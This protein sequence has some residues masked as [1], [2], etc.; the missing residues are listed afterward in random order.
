MPR[1]I[2][3]PCLVALA[4][5]VPGCDAASAPGGGGAVGD[6]L[7]S[8]TAPGQDTPPAADAGAAASVTGPRVVFLGTSLTAGLGLRRP[9]E[10]WPEQL[11]LRAEAAGIPFRVVNAGRSGDTSAGGV[12]RLDWILGDTVDV[13]V[14]ELG[15]NDGLR[16]LP[17][18]EVAANLG[19]VIDRTRAA[20][21]EA[22]ILLVGMEAPTNLGAAYTQA[23]REVFP[24]VAAERGVALVPFLLDGVAGVDSL[25]QADGIHP[26][27]AGHARIA[28]TVWPALEPLVR[29]AATDAAATD[30]RPRAASGDNAGAR[31]ETDR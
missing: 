18:A 6:S 24:A 1:W 9:A 25:N 3:L 16:G 15:A 11:G 8:A 12:A 23:F 4:L 13:L 28:E 7:A 19:T 26:T 31:R 5:A 30:A 14:V 10:R 27:A 2:S 21:P 17:P 20:W 22:R 29:A